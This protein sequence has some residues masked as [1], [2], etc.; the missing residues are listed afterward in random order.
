MAEEDQKSPPQTESG[1][2]ER[3]ESR[4]WRLALFFLVLLATGMAALSWER[5]QRFPYHLGAIPLGLLALAVLFAVYVYGRRREVSDIRNLVDNLQDRAG[6]IPTE[7]QLDQ[8]SQVIMRSQRS[9]KELIDALDDAAFA[10]SLDGTLRTVNRKVAELLGKPYNEIVGHKLDEFIEEPR[11]DDLTPSL[12]YFLEK[13][14]WSGLLTLRL[15]N[16]TRP[17]YFDCIVNAIV[18]DEDV[19]GASVLARD[20]TQEHEKEKRFTELFETL[21]EGVYF[22]TPEGR[23]I[24]V[25]AALV[26]MLGYGSKQEVLALRPADLTYGQGENPLLGNLV[27]KTGAVNEREITL[28]RKDGSPVLL[29]DTSRAVLDAYGQIIR[30]QGTLVNITER[31]QMEKAIRQQEQF[32]RYL[33]ES[34]PDLILVIDMEGRYEFVSARIRDLLGYKPEYLLGRNIDEEKGESPELITLYREIVNGQKVFGFCEYRASHVD[35]SS[36]TMRASA[37]ALYDAE[38]KLN[39]AI[40]SVRDITIERKLEQQVIEN[41]RLA[42]MGQMIGGFAHELNNPLTGILGISELLEDEKHNDTTRKQIAMLQQQTRR[43]AEIVQNLLYFSRPPVPGQT[44]VNL[45]ETI[46]RTLHLHA[47]SLRKNNITIDFLPEKSIPTIKGDQHQLMQLFLNLIVN[48]EQAV[49]EIRDRGT[50]RIRMEK[51]NNW[52]AITFQD[53]G[54]G[55]ATDIL[56]H[57]FDPFYTTKRPGRGTGLGLSICK[58]IVREHGG[59]ID[60]SSG[61]GGGAVFTVTF[62]VTTAAASA[63][64]GNSSVQ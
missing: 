30:F 52:V 44:A 41:E 20:V 63:G 27:D 4:L 16:S 57:I 10:V 5:L 29:I 33:L 12:S 61:P 36:R 22:R 47:Y 42:A 46:Q 62:P 43:A 26:H 56:N 38:H 45:A 3:E 49:H 50:L 31:R 55:I 24:D 6:P 40:I 54:P 23:F 53:D 18:K 60:A 39:G 48:A 1:H 13:R 28:R 35:G 64:S 21:H 14:R 32:Q 8:L 17:L 59:S 25:N 15:R 7:E 11:R 34:F 51:L 19:T 9:F 58:A 2:F 37:S